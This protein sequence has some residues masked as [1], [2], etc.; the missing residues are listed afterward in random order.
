[1][2]RPRRED[3][4][5]LLRL[6]IPV[7]VVQVGIMFMGVVDTLMVGRV[8]PT[9]LAAVAIGVVTIL[10]S[11]DFFRALQFGAFASDVAGVNAAV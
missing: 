6:A 4:L 9:A 8:S 7:V 1:M 5:A 10:L 11:G 2:L 3:I